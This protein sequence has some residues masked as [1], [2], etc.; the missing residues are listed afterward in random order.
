VHAFGFVDASGRKQ[1]GKWIF[2]PLGGT[3]G[4]SD[5]EAKARSTDYLFNE[6]R[7]CVTAGRVASDFMLQLAQPGDRIDSAVTPLPDDRKKVSL[8]HSRRSTRPTVIATLL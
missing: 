1:F 7:Q 8:G 6:L 2:E 4:L 3:Q 5:D